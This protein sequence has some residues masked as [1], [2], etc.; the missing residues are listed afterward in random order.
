[1]FVFEDLTKI[2]DR[3]MQ[4]IMKEI[5]NDVLT[6]ALKTASE[7]LRD[8]MFRSV[9]SRAAE[10]IKEELEVMGPVKLSDVENAQNEIVKVARRLEEEGKI[11]LAG[12]GGGEQLV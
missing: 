12:K 5:G 8:K 4:S 11:V 3:G 6:L 1:M 7:G 10:M 9:S 2:D